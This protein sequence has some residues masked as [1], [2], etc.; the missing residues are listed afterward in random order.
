[1]AEGGIQIRVESQGI[2]ELKE[3]FD[4]LPTKV[5]KRPLQSTLR[6]AAKPLEQEVKNTL[7]VRLKDMGQAVTTKNMRSFAGVKTGVYTKRVAVT[8]GSEGKEKQWDA[9]YLLYWHN[10]GTLSRRDPSH[11]FQK[12]VNIRKSHL[13]PGIHPRR[14]IQKAYESKAAEVVAYAEAHLLADAE[15]FLDRNSNRFLQKQVV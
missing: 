6:R 1:M 14:F 15:K 11:T 12:K 13:S 8:L 3:I 7:P 10:Y 9:Y 4:K 2:D 5:A